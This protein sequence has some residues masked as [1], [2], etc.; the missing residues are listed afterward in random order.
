MNDDDELMIVVVV[1]VMMGMGL[2]FWQW[3]LHSH[4][5]ISNSQFLC[6]WDK[7][8]EDKDWVIQNSKLISQFKIFA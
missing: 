6:T 3:H 8:D 4:H 5:F 2:A 7:H 1:V